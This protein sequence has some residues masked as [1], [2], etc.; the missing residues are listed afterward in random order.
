MKLW[1]GWIG[2]LIT[3]MEK[4]ATVAERTS[5][6]YDQLRAKST[7]PKAALVIVG[8]GG[9]FE[10]LADKIFGAK[11]NDIPPAG[12]VLLPE[13][14]VEGNPW[15]QYMFYHLVE[16]KHEWVTEFSPE[17]KPLSARPAND[18]IRR[19]FATNL[20]EQGEHEID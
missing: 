2:Q 15:A 3:G 7:E 14:T 1:R 18:H 11:V 4:Y 12:I 5:V 10:P 20:Q 9:V 17:G 6:V 16:D 8:H 13:T 19:D